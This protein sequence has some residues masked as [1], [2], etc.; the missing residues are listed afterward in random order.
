MLHWT[1][2]GIENCRG[3]AIHILISARR[4][5][6]SSAG[7][8]KQEGSGLLATGQHWSLMQQTLWCLTEQLQLRSASLLKGQTH[9][10]SSHAAHGHWKAGLCSQVIDGRRR[11]ESLSHCCSPAT[12]VCPS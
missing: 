8:R 1:S 5:V 4:C 6:E 2:T 9:H 12:A 7:R 11:S 10:S 3:K